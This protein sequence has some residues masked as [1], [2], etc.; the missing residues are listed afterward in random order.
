[1]SLKNKP[2]CLGIDPDSKYIALAVGDAEI[3]QG[4][5]SFKVPQGRMEM[6]KILPQI[7]PAFME[8]QYGLPLWPPIIIIEGQ[9][10]YPQSKVR[11][12]DLIKLA[13]LAG[14]A[15]G[16]CASL[17]PGS[18]ILIPEPKDWKGSVPKHIHQ[19]RLYKKLGWG[20]KQTKDYAYPEHPTVGK[21]LLKGEWKHVGDAIGLMQWGA[22]LDAAN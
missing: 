18:R 1:M 20:Y 4:V 11:P 17:Y 19:A 21:K 12:N 2:I 8:E 7:I 22:A 6:I 3:I 13:H 15:A 5:C 16:V 14:A 10:I 9:R